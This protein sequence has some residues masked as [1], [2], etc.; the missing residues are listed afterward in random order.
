MDYVCP[1]CGFSTNNKDVFKT[2][3]KIEPPCPR[4]K[5]VIL[6]KTQRNNLNIVSKEVFSA[7]FI[8]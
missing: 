2:H 6:T 7:Y 3:L 1:E 8:K 4:L 5:N